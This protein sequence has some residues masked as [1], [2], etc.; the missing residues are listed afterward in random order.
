MSLVIWGAGA[1]GG[2]IG[3]FLARA[4][5][6]TLLVDNDPEHV[7][8]INDDDLKIIGPV[9]EFSVSVRATTPENVRG[10]FDKVFLATKAQNTRDAI[11]A[12]KP[13]LTEDGY[14]LSAQNGLNE[15]IIQDVVGKNRTVG[16]LVNFGADYQAPGQ[17][18]FG[19]RGSVVLG[20][21]DGAITERLKQLQSIM[22]DFDD[23]AAITDNISGYLWG[24]MVFGA[25]VFITAL[26]NEAV[27]DALADPTYRSIYTEAAREIVMLAAELGAEPKGFDS[28]DPDVF[29]PEF[30]PSKVDASFDALIALN[31]ESGKTHSG[32][33]RDLAIR[34]RRTEVAMYDVILAEGERLNMP[35]LFTRQW[36]KMIHEIEEGNRQLGIANLD[37]L[38]ANL[39]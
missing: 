23:A 14:V 7:A 33:W 21:V 15:L 6:D 11:E 26:T 22:S 1:I 29:L 18:L 31:R 5:H 13:H 9:E 17:I 24:K 4:G 37:E 8:A 34:K 39:K 30:D 27:A 36:I 2:T 25:I 10:E 16:A 20:E 35:L 38:R 19:G 12:I 28:F 32:V 3:A